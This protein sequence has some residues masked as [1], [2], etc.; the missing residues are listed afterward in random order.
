M[1]TILTDDTAIKLNA[2]SVEEG[3]DGWAARMQVDVWMSDPEALRFVDVSARLISAE[4]GLNNSA[5]EKND[6]WPEPN[7]SQLHFTD[8]DSVKSTFFSIW[9]DHVVE[10]DEVFFIALRD[11]KGAVLAESTRLT[12]ATIINDDH[13]GAGGRLRSSWRDGILH[14]PHIPPQWVEDRRRQDSEDG[15]N[16]DKLES[17]PQHPEL[18]RFDAP[19]EDKGR[20]D[21]D[22]RVDEEEVK[23]G[24]SPV[25]AVFG[26]GALLAHC[27]ECLGELELLDN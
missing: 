21:D 18:P 6:Y 8:G 11:V 24:E 16:E 12:T 7:P 27:F 9:G 13:L 17:P 20:G 14:I 4:I 26:N 10:R 23:L 3:H 15:K 5:T 19:A 25:D 22:G 2:P 1:A